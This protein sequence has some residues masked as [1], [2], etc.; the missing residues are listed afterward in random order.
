MAFCAG[1]A[2]LP[3]GGVSTVTSLGLGQPLGLVLLLSAFASLR[4]DTM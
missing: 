4:L 1:L 3:F 2:R